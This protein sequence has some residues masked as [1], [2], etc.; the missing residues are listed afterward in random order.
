[1]LLRSGVVAQAGCRKC[2]RF[3]RSDHSDNF[4]QGASRT[5][6]TKRTRT[7]TSIFNGSVYDPG[8]LI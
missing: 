4:A 2:A 5:I 7:K 3:R 1:M 8:E 6:G